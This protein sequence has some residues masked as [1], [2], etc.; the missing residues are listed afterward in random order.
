[1]VPFFR[2]SIWI[3][4]VGSA[5]LLAEKIFMGS[6][7]LLVKILRRRP[8]RMYTCTPLQ[9]DEELGSA[10]FPMVIVQIPMYNEKEVLS[11]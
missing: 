9:E 8:N 1:M 11:L 7:S 5:M 2:I 3:C 10:A 4:I 6:V